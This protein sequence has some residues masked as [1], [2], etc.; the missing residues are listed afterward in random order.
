MEFERDALDAIAASSAD[1]KTASQWLAA[2]VEG[3]NITAECDLS[4]NPPVVTIE[5][6]RKPGWVFEATLRPKV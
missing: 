2:A 1:V 5:F 6:L 4:K 3:Q